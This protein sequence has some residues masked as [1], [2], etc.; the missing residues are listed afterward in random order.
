MES[1]TKAL[2]SFILGLVGMIAWIIPIAGLAV[3]IVG[4]VFG[5]MAKDA[6]NKWMAIAGI[7]LCIIGLVASV[8][9][10]T[11]NVY[12]SFTENPASL[13]NALI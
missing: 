4:L 8:V 2:W 13:L 11:V 10:W 12:S 3:Q 9:A 7:V 6:P 1:K 5:I